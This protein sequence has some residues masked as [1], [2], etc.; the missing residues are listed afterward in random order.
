MFSLQTTSNT[1]HISFPTPLSFPMLAHVDATR[2]PSDADNCFSPGPVTRWLEQ[3]STSL[4]TLT[5]P[6]AL[7]F[8]LLETVLLALLTPCRTNWRIEECQAIR[9]R[10]HKKAGRKCT[11]P[12]NNPCSAVGSNQTG[13]LHVITVALDDITLVERWQQQQQ[14]QQQWEWEWQQWSDCGACKPP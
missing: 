3:C 1:K 4:H 6:G 5:E 9:C 11:D 2:I 8:V 7:P 13:R 12:A 14:Q 10:K